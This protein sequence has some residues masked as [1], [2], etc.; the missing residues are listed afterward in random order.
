MGTLAVKSALWDLKIPK[1]RG[2][3]YQQ[4]QSKTGET[5]HQ[6]ESRDMLGMKGLLRSGPQSKARSGK[7]INVDFGLE[8]Y[9]DEGNPLS[10]R[11]ELPVA[12]TLNLSGKEVFVDAT[13]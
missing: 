12:I 2:V 1:T 8:S 5:E 13:N 4:Q 6:D 9:W 10:N 7:N 3:A 11:D